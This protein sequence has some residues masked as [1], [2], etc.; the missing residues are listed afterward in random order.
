MKKNGGW[1]IC[2]CQSSNGAND[3]F[4]SP[5]LKSI[6]LI[7]VLSHQP[8]VFVG[9]IDDSFVVGLRG[10]SN[11][12]QYQ[13]RSKSCRFQPIG[14]TWANFIHCWGQI[15]SVAARRITAGLLIVN[16]ICVLIDVHRL[17]D[18]VLDNLPF[19]VTVPFQTAVKLGGKRPLMTASQSWW[20][21]SL[22]W[23]I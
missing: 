13:L 19:I 3:S 16:R 21:P 8:I 15:V 1:H 4:V 18:A 14:G 17:W 5:F 6:I 10:G 20:L 22:G 7:M 2:L 12:L 11:E 23:L 9:Y